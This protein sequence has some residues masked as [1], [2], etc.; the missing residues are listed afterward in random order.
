VCLARSQ[1]HSIIAR[2]RDVEDIVRITLLIN[3][4]LQ[5]N[6]A[7]NLLLP[8]LATQHELTVFYSGQV[9]K[10]S[11]ISQVSQLAF[12]EQTLPNQL[13]FPALD[14]LGQSG[15]LRT[16][17]GLTHYLETP[18]QPLADPNSDIG[19]KTLMSARPDLII[20]IRYGHIL[21]DRAI[22]IP[23][24]GVINLHSGRLPA[25]RGVMATFRAMLNND[26]ELGCT[27]HWVDSASIDA[28]P[29]ICR[30]L[31]PRQPETCYLENVLKL[32]DAGCASLAETIET[33]AHDQVPESVRALE[34]GS[35]F[36]FPT[37]G[38]ITRFDAA[39]HQWVNTTRLTDLL[40]RYFANP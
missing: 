36:S 21:L 39:G 19:T 25:Y 1:R 30:N 10:P 16:F 2:S 27:L 26:A 13:L 20:S 6:Y 31:I 3:L 8:S 37:Q 18:L 7:L 33:L 22:S 34:P 14:A 17:T 28:G 9:G 38:D 15:A 23:R 32:Y 5:S 4:D 35:Y 11:R 24:I 40:A 12:F 29:I